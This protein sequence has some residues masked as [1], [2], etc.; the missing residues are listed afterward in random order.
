MNR[1]ARR[2]AVLVVLLLLLAAGTVFFLGEFLSDSGDW[3]LF[4][5]SPHLYSGNKVSTGMIADRTG[6]LL[7]DLRDGRTYAENASVRK[8]MLHWVGDRKGNVSVPFVEH[9]AKEL[10]GYDAVNGVYT[11]GDT[12]GT[13]HLTLSAQ[14]IGRAHV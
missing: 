3:I 13:I 8:S 2:A 11:Y 9:Y 14:E 5:G 12:Y 7:V 10:L 4:S 6:G 1:I